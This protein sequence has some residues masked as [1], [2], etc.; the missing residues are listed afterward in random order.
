MG[1]PSS[2]MESSWKIPISPHRYV[3]LYLTLGSFRLAGK[4]I[5]AV[6]LYAGKAL[7]FS[8]FFFFF[9]WLHHIVCRILVSDQGS[10]LCPL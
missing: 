7:I 4:G 1:I 3:L 2:W 10:N 8:G 5:L 9:F 6:R